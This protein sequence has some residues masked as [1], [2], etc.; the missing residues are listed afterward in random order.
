MSPDT[1]LLIHKNEKS[2]HQIK[3]KSWYF[4]RNL[5][6]SESEI[7]R[8]E[9]N[10]SSAKKKIVRHTGDCGERGEKKNHQQNDDSPGNLLNVRSIVWQRT[11][12][13]F[14]VN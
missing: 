2:L 3:K 1:K 9:R 4:L 11:Y 10:I 6:F 5:I 8:I 14:R 7:I 13:I 12:M